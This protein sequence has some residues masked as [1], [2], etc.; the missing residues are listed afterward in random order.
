MAVPAILGL[1]A[2]SGL[3]GTLTRVVAGFFIASA[4]KK[5]TILA[6][7]V[8]VTYFATDA[9]LGF[10]DGIVAS[11]LAGA[12]PEIALIGIALPSNTGECISLIISTEITCLTYA[13]TMRSLETQIQIVS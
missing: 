10:L 9:L 11:L 4:V 2:L 5:L 1:G 6:T 13:L 8:T 12:P 7:Y 3:I